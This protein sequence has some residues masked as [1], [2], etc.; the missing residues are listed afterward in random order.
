MTILMGVTADGDL[1]ARAVAG[2]AAAFG[3]L[4]ERHAKRVYNFCF[5][6]TANWAEAEDAMAE[7]F[8]VAWKRRE[9]VELTTDDRSVLPWLLGVA[10]NVLR[11]RARSTRRAAAAVA[12]VDARSI[13]RDFADDLV[14]RLSDEKQM[15]DILRVV[16]RLPPQE[17]D[18]LAVCAWAGLSYEEAA[19]ALGVPLGTVRSRLSRARAHIRELSAMNGHDVGNERV[20]RAA[21]DRR[22]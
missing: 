13:E 4:F 21:D 7:V 20:A 2:E 8:L 10:L 3:E 14:G 18:V 15:N 16:H 11:N 9:T 1:W 22:G 17:Q 12:R 5:R 6:Q 19:I